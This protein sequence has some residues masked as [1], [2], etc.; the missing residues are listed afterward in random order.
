VV[1]LLW[2]LACSGGEGG[3]D[4]E[5]EEE[6]FEAP[7][8]VSVVEAAAVG[9]GSVADRLT[10]SAV[11][12]SEAMAEL[13]P[14]SSGV[15]TSVDADE[16]D[17]VRA[18]QLLAT[19]ENVSLSTG[20]AKARGEVARLEAQAAGTRELVNRGAASARE[21][22]EAEHQLR[23]AQLSARE[24]SA[25]F[26]TTR[27]VA[28]FDGVVSRRD[29]RVGEF[30]TSARAAFQVVDLQRLR[31]V[32]SLPERDIGKVLVGQP[33]QLASAYDDALV[34]TGRVARVSPV[35]DSAT[36]TFRVTIAVDEGQ[37]LRP[38]QFVAVTV[39]VGRHDDVIVV[40]KSALVYEDGAPVLYAVEEAPAPDP[41]E[42]KEGEDA[43]EGGA[44]SW[45]PFGGDDAAG[46]G[47]G[48]LEP[49]EVPGDALVAER[50]AVQV[51]LVDA[52][53]AEIRSGVDA[54]E[55]IVT[56][57]QSHLRDGA[58]V[59]PLDPAAK[60]AVD[61]AAKKAAEPAAGEADE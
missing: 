14:E 59:R 54:G 11:V 51:G 48:P 39:E 29:V 40:P 10:A 32:A 46:D 1:V 4:G 55:T 53:W 44:W 15:V 13:V 25:G 30:V 33:V 56:V 21:L 31:V 42:A 34:V 61:P 18:G 36:G 49:T 9:R 2:L 27:I 16:G 23:V 37:A 58:K 20:A 24:A 60:K 28:P 43:D 45:W 7:E 57:G 5:G 35:V 47:D 12:E 38:G 22:Q 8:P 41:D 19:L 26:G 6:A 52:S 50:R 17:V 3:P